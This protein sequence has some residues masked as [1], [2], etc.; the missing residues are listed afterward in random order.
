MLLSYPELSITGWVLSIF[1]LLQLAISMSRFSSK[2]TYSDVHID[3]PKIVALAAKKWHNTHIRTADIHHTQLFMHELYRY[4]SS[5]SVVCFFCQKKKK[6]TFEKRPHIEMIKVN[7]RTG[8]FCIFII[9]FIFMVKSLGIFTVLIF[10]VW[11]DQFHS[12]IETKSVSQK[13]Y[14]EITTHKIVNKKK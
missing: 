3:L 12:S 4:I 2:L 8:L 6:P 10:N 7:D 13:L 11:F 9:Y 5:H 1:D 14:C